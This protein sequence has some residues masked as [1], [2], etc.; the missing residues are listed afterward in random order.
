MSLKNE[1]TVTKVANVP[2]LICCPTAT[3]SKIVTYL[4]NYLLKSFYILQTIET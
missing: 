1:K 4:P 3:I 2:T